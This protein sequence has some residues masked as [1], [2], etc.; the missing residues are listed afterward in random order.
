MFQKTQ[1][2]SIF[3]STDFI[4]FHYSLLCGTNGFTTAKNSPSHTSPSVRIAPNEN[5]TMWIM[6][7]QSSPIVLPIEPRILRV[8]CPLSR[9][10]V[11]P[12]SS[13]FVRLTLTNYLSLTNC[14]IHTIHMIF[15]PLG[16]N[17]ICTVYVH[18]YSIEFVDFFAAR[19]P[20]AKT[21]NMRKCLSIAFRA[22]HQSTINASAPQLTITDGA[23]SFFTWKQK[24]DFTHKYNSRNRTNA[25]PH[26]P[27]Q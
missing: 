26:D 15:L 6:W 24:F 3:V 4:T 12:S 17:S 11:G 7:R 23:S 22:I 21:S 9:G 13:C 20:H 19:M 2:L 8:A 16:S 10:F 25:T 1:H 27:R 18:W 5:E 14:R